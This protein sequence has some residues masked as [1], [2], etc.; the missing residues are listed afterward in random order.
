[1]HN[2]EYLESQ[3]LKIQYLKQKYVNITHTVLKLRTDINISKTDVLGTL[4]PFLS[5]TKILTIADNTSVFY[6]Y[7]ISTIFTDN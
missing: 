1:M 4:K 3:V 6:I 7:Q 5:A 2:G